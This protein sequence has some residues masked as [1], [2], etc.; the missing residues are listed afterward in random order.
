MVWDLAAGRTWFGRQVRDDMFEGSVQVFQCMH[1]VVSL[2]HTAITPCT[3][4]FVSSCLL[5]MTPRL[6]TSNASTMFQTR[7]PRATVVGDVLKTRKR[8]WWPVAS[9]ASDTF[10]SED[11][12]GQGYMEHSICGDVLMSTSASPVARMACCSRS[13]LARPH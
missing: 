9:P 2:R 3:C 10:A 8:N 4:A 5:A 12:T 13:G 1:R 6:S 7:P 11:P